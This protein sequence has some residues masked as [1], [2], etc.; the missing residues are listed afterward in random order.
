MMVNLRDA[1]LTPNKAILDRIISDGKRLG[2]M[3]EDFKVAHWTRLEMGF[4]AV[5][6][7]SMY[8][9]ILDSVKSVN[10]YLVKM[11]RTLLDFGQDTSLTT[12]TDEK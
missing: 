3:L 1:F 4:C 12:D 9:D 10:E 2:D 11:S 7:S 5:E 6:A 8:R